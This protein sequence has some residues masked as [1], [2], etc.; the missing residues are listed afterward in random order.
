MKNP[1]QKPEMIF[2][3]F[4]GVISKNSVLDNIKN[5]HWFINQYTPLP[6]EFV[7]SFFKNTMCFSVQH[8]INFL[9]SSLG[10][11]DKL[12]EVY[13]EQIIKKFYDN[14][15]IK[16]EDDFFQFIDF[17]DHNS[18]QYLIYSSRDN[19]IKKLSET[20]NQF[21]TKNIYDLKGRSKANYK[22]FPEVAKELELNLDKCIYIDD[23]PLALRTGKINGMTTIM[24][25]NDI[26]TV[27]DYQIFSPYIDYTINTFTELSEIFQ[28]L[29]PN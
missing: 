22:T 21:N 25:L 24:M 11:E 8:T 26:F 2:I 6:L 17:C 15:Q 10:I 27:E 28:H 16:I 7:I 4:D 29:I 14:T 23:T 9:F 18:L 3:D 5:V 19:S 20:I 1:I 13:Q 12:F